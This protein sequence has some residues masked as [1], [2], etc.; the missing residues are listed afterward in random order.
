MAEK[1]YICT[2]AEEMNE[3]WREKLN[4]PVFSTQHGRREEEGG[5]EGAGEGA[6]T[7]VEAL[8]RGEEERR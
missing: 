2:N 5:G 1:Q 4:L 6:E 3:G 8:N 7:P